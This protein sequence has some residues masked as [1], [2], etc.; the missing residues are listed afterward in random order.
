MG[1][2]DDYQVSGWNSEH[3]CEIY[4]AAVGPTFISVD[5]N[6]HPHRSVIV[7]IYMESEWIVRMEWSAYYLDL[8]AI[9]ILWDV[10]DRAVWKRSSPQAT[11]SELEIA[12]Q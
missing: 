11:L 1:F 3:N 10:L 5:N 9:K 4:A 8:N 6:V 7:D 12:L 2:C